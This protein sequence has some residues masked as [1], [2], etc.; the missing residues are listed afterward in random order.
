[1][2]AKGNL[3]AF[4]AIAAM[5]MVSTFLSERRSMKTWA[6]NA[7]IAEPKPI[8]TGKTLALNS[9]PATVVPKS[10]LGIAAPATEQQAGSLAERPATAQ[11]S[12]AI[13][14]PDAT[15]T[16]PTQ[17]RPE[18][19]KASRLSNYRRAAGTVRRAEETRRAL[20]RSSREPIQFRLAEGRT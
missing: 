10:D 8:E 9:S 12:I 19:S 16:L 14:D 5:L 2:K 20:A 13:I 6:P 3:A 18:L 15:A 4:A 1:M 17:P 11:P 7:V